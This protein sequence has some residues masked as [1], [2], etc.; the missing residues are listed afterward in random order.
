MNKI[1]LMHYKYENKGQLYRISG[2]R[3]IQKLIKI[4]YKS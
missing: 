2:T 4:N 1:I 3:Y